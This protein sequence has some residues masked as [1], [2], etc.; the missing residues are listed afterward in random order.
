[1]NRMVSIDVRYKD[2]QGKRCFVP[3]IYTAKAR[4]KPQLGAVDYIRWYQGSKPKASKVG[5]D[6]TAV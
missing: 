6:R 2:Q 4:H 3:A 5:T 1:M